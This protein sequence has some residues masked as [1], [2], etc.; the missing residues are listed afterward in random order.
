VFDAMLEKATHLCD[1]AFGIMQT[2]DGEAFHAM[3]HYNSPPQFVEF[4]RTPLRPMHGMASY[5]IVH[6]ED[7]V[8]FDDI[9]TDPVYASGSTLTRRLVE[10]TGARSHMT[11]ALRKDGVLLGEIVMYRREVRSFTDKQV[12]LVKNFAAQAV[13]AMEN[14]RLLSELRERTRDLEESLEY[15]TATSD[16][17][18]VISRSTFDLQPVL[19][20]LVETAARLCSAD[21]GLISSREEDGLRVTATFSTTPEFEAFI[22]GRL[23]PLTRGSLADALFSYGKLFKYPTLPPIPNSQSPR[24]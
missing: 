24:L 6:G 21:L 11:V 19:D 22:R 4:L 10:L 17:L 3:A 14:A 7:V 8:T 13:I 2:Y 12:A 16:V 1:A 20:T 18:K 5:R 23:L 15:Q 9:A